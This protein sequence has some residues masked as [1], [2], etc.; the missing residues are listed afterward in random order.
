[1]RSQKIFLLFTGC[2]ISIVFTRFYEP[3][4]RARRVFIRR[5][6]SLERALRYLHQ[7]FLFSLHMQL[8]VD[9]GAFKSGK[10]VVKGYW[11]I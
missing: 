1:M 11:C 9:L 5:S 10:F 6:G 8:M 2:L 4:L 7:V 3:R